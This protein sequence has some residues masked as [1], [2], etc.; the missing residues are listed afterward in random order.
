MYRFA[1]SLADSQAKRFGDVL[2][3]RVDTF[4]DGNHQIAVPHPNC[5]GHNLIYVCSYFHNDELKLVD[6]R[7]MQF[8]SERGA[9]HLTVIVPF[10]GSATNERTENG[11]T[12]AGVPYE[13][14]AVAATDAKAFGVLGNGNT[15]VRVLL[16]DLHTLA[17]RFYFPP[18][19]S[20]VMESTLPY[21]LR[22]LGGDFDVVVTPDDGAKKRF[23][24]Y[25]AQ[26]PSTYYYK[27]R[28]P[29]GDERV[30]RAAEPE[31]VKGKRIL[32]VD[33]LTRSGGTLAKCAIQCRENGAT[34]VCVY[35][36][37]SV[38]P[39]HEETLFAEGGKYADA[40]DRFHT[41]ST[42]PHVAERLGRYPVFNV[43]DFS[44]IVSQSEF[45]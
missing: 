45:L 39:K 40:I 2:C 20:V 37:H 33:D 18:C 10:F 12:A 22:Q 36:A 35:V 17:N 11:V 19:V 24:E 44:A 6:L 1:L 9:R 28:V 23:G 14:V 31:M 30:L 42:L 43:L 3:V 34:R 41:T 5:D 8:L 4:P 7:I 15:R 16:Y 25:F 21:A 29:G 38:F 13:T 32:I 26:F 27:E